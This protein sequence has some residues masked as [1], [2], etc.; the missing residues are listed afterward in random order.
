[1]ARQR[2]QTLRQEIIRC[3]EA[4]EMTVRDISQAVGIM[5]KDVCHHLGFIEKTVRRQKKK[6]MM[7]PCCCLNCGFRFKNRK[8]F[9]RP[10]KCPECRSSRISPA[11][12]RIMP[13]GS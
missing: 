12:F 6:F 10:G 11:M 7:A 8:R 9:T 4:G 2:T 13:S 5:E 3:L 1:M